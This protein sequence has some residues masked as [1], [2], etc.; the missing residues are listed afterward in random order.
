MSELLYSRCWR[1]IHVV[2]FLSLIVWAVLA[3]SFCEPIDFHNSVLHQFEET[4][5]QE[6]EQHDY[7]ERLADEARYQRE[8]EEKEDK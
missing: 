2:C 1:L 5:R 6:Q 7:I 3:S 4:E 8:Q